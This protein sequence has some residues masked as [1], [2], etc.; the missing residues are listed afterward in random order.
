MV[1]GFC[2]FVTCG[3]DQTDHDNVKFIKK[4]IKKKVCVNQYQITMKTEIKYRDN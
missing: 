4:K 3:S 1:F 2:Q